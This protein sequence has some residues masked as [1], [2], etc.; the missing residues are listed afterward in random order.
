M[1]N[2]TNNPHR[3]SVYTSEP[4]FLKQAELAKD[5]LKNFLAVRGLGAA[6]IIKPALHDVLNATVRFSLI[7]S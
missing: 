3:D 6:N 2:S 1:S 5:A 4:A 7:R